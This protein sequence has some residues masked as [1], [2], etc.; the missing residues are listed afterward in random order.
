VQMESIQI[1]KYIEL[2]KLG[3]RDAFKNIVSEYQQLV[4][5]LAFKLLCNEQDAEDVTQDTFIKVWQNINL[6]KKQYKFSTWIYK[7]TTH[8]C[9]DKL[10][11]KNKTDNIDIEDYDCASEENQ[12]EVLHHKELKKL[13]V[14]LTAGLSPKQRLVFTLSDLEEMKA[15]EIKLITGIS[16]AKIKSNLYLARKYMKSKIAMY[17]K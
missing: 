16:A 9:Y 12:E 1:N 6:Y 4:Y 10:R 8:I 11:S 2:C 5:S 13:I 17:E 7:I 14:K 15:E 3:N